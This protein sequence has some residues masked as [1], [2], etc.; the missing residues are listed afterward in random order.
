MSSDKSRYRGY[1]I[2]LRQEWSNWCASVQPTTAE[3]PMLGLSPL[4][5]LSPSPEEALASAK[6]YVDRVLGHEPEKNVA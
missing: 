2:R 3:L 4:N 6:G 1:E 5:T